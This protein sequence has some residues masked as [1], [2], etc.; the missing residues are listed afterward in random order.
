VLGLRDAL[1]PV[2][3]EEDEQP[4]QRQDQQDLENVVPRLVA[5]QEAD[6]RQTGIDEPDQQQDLQLQP[7]RHAA[8][9]RLAQHR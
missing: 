9:S 6:R 1:A 4:G 3:C 7:R 5:G 2:A 8:A